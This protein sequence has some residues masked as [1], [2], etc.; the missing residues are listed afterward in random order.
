[1][2]HRLAGCLVMCAILVLSVSCRRL[3][4]PGRGEQH[5]ALEKLTQPDSIPAKWGKLVSVSSVPA[6]ENWVQLWFQ[7]DE[8]NIRVVPYNVRGNY[9]SS[10]AMV[11]R[12]D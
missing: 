10:Q 9:L 8:G 6:F 5:L 7:D 4:E 12:R 11:I 2:F 1:M 3:G